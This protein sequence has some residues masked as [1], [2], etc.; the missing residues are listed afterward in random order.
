MWLSYDNL[1]KIVA[2]QK[3]YRGRPNDYPTHGR[4]FRRHGHKFFR[5]DVIDNEVVFR[6]NYYNR[7]NKILCNEAEG[8]MLKKL[9]REVQSQNII[10]YNENSQTYTETKDVQYFYYEV[11]PNEIGIVRPDNTFEFTSETNLGQG[12]RQYLENYCLKYASVYTNCRLGGVILDGRIPLF[13]GLRI[14]LENM[15]PV[16]NQNIELFKKI[17]NRSAAKE[18]FEPYKEM[19]S[20]SKAMLSQMDDKLFIAT[21]KD[22]LNDHKIVWEYDPEKGHHTKYTSG[23]DIVK[24]ADKLR[25]E[26]SYF[27]S[28]IL[29][30]YGYDLGGIN[31]R[32]RHSDNWVKREPFMNME[33][34]IRR[35]V[36]QHKK[37]FDLKPMEYG[38]ELSSS[39]WGFVIKQDGKSVAQYSY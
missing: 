29:Y 16:E 4:A 5:T 1:T 33:R 15:N 31:W 9:G 28:A 27:D 32:L 18:L 21:M 6:V 17:V 20:V 3:P 10:V 34:Y 14:D 19:L 26:G 25:E 36:Y 35:V 23:S 7:W 12:V 2:S 13:K 8:A 11:L 37:P 22:V 39:E 38:K 30:N 24:I